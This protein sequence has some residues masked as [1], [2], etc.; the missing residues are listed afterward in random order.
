MDP[1]SGE[2]GPAMAFPY[3][4]VEVHA[5]EISP[6]D[7]ASAGDLIAKV[8]SALLIA[9]NQGWIPSDR[10]KQVL[11]LLLGHVGYDY[12]PSSD[13][14]E[15]EG[16]GPGAPKETEQ[17]PPSRAAMEEGVRAALAS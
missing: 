13:Q 17:E 7:M 12:E 15:D 8:A 5:P 6:K 10:S 2:M 9:E 1:L 14:A 16:E 4:L 3:E 11:A